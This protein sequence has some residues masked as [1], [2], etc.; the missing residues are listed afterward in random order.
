MGETA[1][2][3]GMSN[4]S[5]LAEAASVKDLA[6]RAATAADVSWIV[7]LDERSTGQAKPDYWRELLADFDRRSGGAFLAAELKG[8]PVGFIA[9]E[10]RAFEFGSEPSGWVF[11][12]NVDA[13]I[14]VHGVGE[15]LFGAL[16]EIFRRAGVEK[17][18]TLLDRKNELVLAFFRGQGMTAGPFI[19]LEKDLD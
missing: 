12:L 17:V 13:E 14:R 16:C 4:P 2:E 3:N 7:Q 9:G 5:S 8:R 6:I 18:R 19:Q 10:V 11:A 15:K 1:T